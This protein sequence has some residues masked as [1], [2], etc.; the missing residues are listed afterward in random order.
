[1]TTELLTDPGHVRQDMQ[2]MEHAVKRSTKNP[3]IPI[4]PAIIQAMPKVAGTILLKGNPR[5]QLRAGALLLAFMEYN[6]AV[7]A[8]EQPKQI[9]HHHTHELGPVTENN[10]EAQRAKR[11]AR[12]AGGM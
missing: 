12:L 10:I 5:E 4:P 11:L 1:M 3:E 6:K 8:D 2:L 9:E 7:Q